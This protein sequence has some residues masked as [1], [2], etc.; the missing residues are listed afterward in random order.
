MNSRMNA[1]V[2][3]VDDFENLGTMIGQYLGHHG[4]IARA[5]TT[6]DAARRLI[7]DEPLDVLV[8]DIHMPD[9]DGIAFLAEVKS[10]HPNLPVI[11]LTGAGYVEDLMR[12]SLEL[13]A[14]GFLSKMQPLS[15]VLMEIHRVLRERPVR[16][17]SKAA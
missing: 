13:G 1:K 5:V 7:D 15:Q 4:Y 10:T 8:L 14:S 12:D 9:G 2:L 11:M 3:I 6:L 17:S 16:K